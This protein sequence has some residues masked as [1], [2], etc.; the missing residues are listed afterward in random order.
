MTV[1]WFIIGLII[2]F[3]LGALGTKGADA[4]KKELYMEARLN[5]IWSVI[6]AEIKKGKVN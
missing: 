1:L 2:G 4:R 6:E 3:T 5:R